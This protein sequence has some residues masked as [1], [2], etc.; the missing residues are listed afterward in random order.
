MNAALH[1][2]GDLVLGAST[3]QGFFPLSSTLAANN[4]LAAPFATIADGHKIQ[5][6]ES[7]GGVLVDSETIFPGKDPVLVT[8]IS[9][10]LH[11]NGDLVHVHLYCLGL[12]V[13]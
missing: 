6:P 11:L 10:A 5:V 12:M 1:S 7:G 3:I 2:N 13:W 9:A 4:A 8:G